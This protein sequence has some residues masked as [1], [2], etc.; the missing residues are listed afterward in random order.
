MTCK[1]NLLPICNRF[2]V[3][4]RFGPQSKVSGGVEVLEVMLLTVKG[5]SWQMMGCKRG[6]KRDW[7]PSRRIWKPAE[8]DPFLG[9]KCLQ[10]VACGR[11]TKRQR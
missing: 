1:V 5:F 8:N 6:E 7:Q 4:L 11:C 2:C 9:L 10:Q 3:V